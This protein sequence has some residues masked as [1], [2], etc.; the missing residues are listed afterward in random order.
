M[1]RN[2]NLSVAVALL[3]LLPMLCGLPSTC[4]AVV[5]FTLAPSAVSNTYSGP[6]TLTVSGIASGGSVVVQKFL[7]LNS[8]GTVDGG[9]WLV[10]QFS[11]TDGQP[12][13]VIGSVTNFNVPGDTDTTAGQITAKLNFN[14]ADFIQTVAGKFLFKVSGNFT[15]P[16][17]NVFTVTNF[18]WPQKFTGT[19]F[20]NGTSTTLSNMVV[21]LLKGQQG[22]ALMGAVA[23]NAGAY[24][25]PAPPDTYALVAFGNNRLPD[26]STAPVL[27][28]NSLV[29]NTVNL[30]AT[31]ATSSISGRLVDAAIPTLGLPGIMIPLKSSGL[32]GIGFTDTNG[33][34]TVGVRSGSWSFKAD[35]PGLLLHGYMR[36]MNG[37]NANAGNTTFTNAVPKGNA[38]IYGS[39]KDVLGNPMPGIDVYIG[40]GNALNPYQT[41]GF[42]D[43]NGNYVAAVVGG[44]G[45]N[46]LYFP[47]IATDNN[48]HN[49]T[50]YMFTV[51]QLSGTIATNTAVL[52]NFTGMV[53]TNHVFGKVTF[54]GTNVVGVGVGAGQ[55]I[56]AAHFWTWAH[57]DTN[58][59]YVLNVGNGTWDIG[60]YCSA[61]GYPDGLDVILGTGN[62]VC[63]DD[64]FPTIN[65][66]NATNN[67]VVQPS[68]S[69]SAPS[70]ATC[71][72]VGTNLLLGVA[73]GV[74]GKT[75]LLLASTNLA[76]PLNQWLPVTTNALSVGGNFTMTVTN[77]VTPLARQK[78]FILQTL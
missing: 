63:P 23:N 32:M 60:I 35:E 53:A 11:L 24:T 18:P 44:L 12:G 68:G 76:L 22:S 49:P 46:E 21:L 8:S 9:D 27:T 74:A 33:N 36:L 37:T 40:D 58:G 65:N 28:L 30:T 59:N 5:A 17:T 54:V 56:S 72:T 50:N 64:Q 38:L 78:F 67:F 39:V 31:N 19:V 4:S 66:N 48:D 69:N 75:Y 26:F 61:D 51:S 34:F 15:P 20:S 6:I 47:E 29:T 14:N 52:Q 7:D 1:K 42:T 25:I 71:A 10:Q 77:V 16:I 3:V 41:D 57:T 45:T 43:A 55:D 13:M 62:F 2:K 70:I 73:N